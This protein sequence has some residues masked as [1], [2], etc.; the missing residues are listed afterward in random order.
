[1]LFRSLMIDELPEA[2]GGQS[3]VVALVM[4]YSVPLY[5]YP[6][7]MTQAKLTWAF[8]RHGQ[9][10][11][12]TATNSG[13]RHVRISALKLHD[14]GMTLASLGDGLLGY[15]LGHSTMRWK[16][17]GDPQRLT[18]DHPVMVIAQGDTGPINVQLPAPPIR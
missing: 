12:L 5:F 10:L 8:E 9:Q 11:Y 14:G 3:G 15:V 13:D 4:R 17:P 18:V 7:Q 1:V 16:V 2:A 6:R